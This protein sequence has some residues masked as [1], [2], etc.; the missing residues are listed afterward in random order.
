[1][2]EGFVC[3]EEQCVEKGECDAERPCAGADLICNMEVGGVEEVCQYCDLETLQCKPG[4]DTDDNC[5]GS[6]ACMPDH[7]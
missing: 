6:L 5:E 3:E 1:M 2:Q 4:C 7:T